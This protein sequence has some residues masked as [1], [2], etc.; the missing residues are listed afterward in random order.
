[1]DPERLKASL[2]GYFFWVEIE[3][4]SS[5]LESDDIARFAEEPTIR[6]YFVR[7]L[8]NRLE[9]STSEREKEVLSLALR[10]GLAAFE[11]R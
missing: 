2:R 11:G 10:K 6:G 7:R 5:Y 8:L 9:D 4:E 3:D 1:V